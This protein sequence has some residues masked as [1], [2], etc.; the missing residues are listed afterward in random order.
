MMSL[1]HLSDLVLWGVLNPSYKPIS[2]CRSCHLCYCFVYFNC[3]EMHHV[4]TWIKLV[5]VTFN[6][7]V[8][9]CVSSRHLT[10]SISKFHL[11]PNTSNFHWFNVVSYQNFSYRHCLLIALC[12]QI[13]KQWG[14]MECNHFPTTT[15]LWHKIVIKKAKYLWK[16]QK[17]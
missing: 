12:Q 13:V 6:K 1:F 3:C 8:P 11:A 14:D 17:K 9:S 4:L 7:P 15:T 10:I 16:K 2:L 5:D